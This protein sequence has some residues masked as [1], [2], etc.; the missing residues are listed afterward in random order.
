MLSTVVTLLL[1]LLES[2]AFTLV[3]TLFVRPQVAPTTYFVFVY[4]GVVAWRA[5]VRG[6]TAEPGAR[7][8]ALA[9]IPLVIAAVVAL[10]GIPPLGA[11]VVWL[12]VGIVLQLAATL[13]L[14]WLVAVATAPN[15]DVAVVAGPLLTVLMFAAPVVYPTALV[16]LALRPLFLANPMA[17]AIEAY[18]AALLSGVPPARDAVAVATLVA[19]GVLSAGW[20][21]TRRTRGSAHQLVTLLTSR[22]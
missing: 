11:L 20:V 4:V 6:V 17:T 2:A 13:G 14:G 7:R 10:R 15:R 8:D 5:F 21:C 18:R 1:P 19:G 3:F 9:A 12:P 22:R 16:P